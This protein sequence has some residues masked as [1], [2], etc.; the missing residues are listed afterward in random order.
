[1]SK[2][3]KEKFLT[4]IY[5]RL[6]DEDY[7]KKREVSESIEN[8]L[9][10]CREYIAAHPDL[11][12]VEVYI[13]DGRTGLNYNR[14]GYIRMMEDVDDGK[15]NCIITK[16]L[17][18]LGREHAETIKLFKQTFVLKDIRYIAVVDNIDFNGSINSMEIPLKVVM[19]DNYSMETSKNIRSVF[20]AKAK[21]GDFIGSF[22]TY[23]Y[24]KNPKDRNKLLVDPVAAEVVKRIYSEFI[25]GKNISTIVHGLNEDGLPCPSEYKRLEGSNYSNNRKL[26]KTNYW[27]YSTV[28]KILLNENENYIGNMVQ[29]RTEK[30]AY[31]LEKLVQVP[32]DE[33]IRK[34]NTHEPIITKEDY[35]LVH[36]LIKQRWRN[37]DCSRNAKWKFAGLIFCGDCGRYLT[38]S[39]RK[40]GKVL[41]C[42]TYSRIGKEYC[43]QHLIYQYEME[44]LV[45]NAIQENVSDAL[46]N[47][48][49]EKARENEKRLDTNEENSKLEL[50]LN[51]LERNY[52]KMVM[53]LSMDIID[54]EDFKVFKQQYQDKK[55]FIIERRKALQERRN[56]AT[57]YMSEY[58]R[59]LDN[60]L[61][62][63]E[64]D[65]LSREVLV[66]LI[67][68]IDVY[69]NKRINISFKFKKPN[70]NN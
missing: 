4:A 32:K 67:D 29:H 6:S 64:I 35:D 39:T 14:T 47:M 9:A 17:A 52:K 24:K 61:K 25:G 33:W 65:E 38:R 56:S 63:R 36:K 12:E 49:L 40:D 59:W 23:G 2:K 37:M 50:Q 10:I 62:Y 13:D 15:I 60:F 27:T 51:N 43:S 11:E 18:R 53:N 3:K 30:K 34:E 8:Q 69:E 46:K 45:L 1:M 55:K 21:S 42:S 7:V 16:S 20:L 44:E 70:Q 31:N 58:Q 19:N 26:E 22:A 5:L 57:L 48:D 68:R 28:K 41:R 66:N 54:E